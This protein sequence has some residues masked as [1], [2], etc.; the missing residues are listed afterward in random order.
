MKLELNKIYQGDVSRVLKTWPAAFI[1]TVVTSPPYWGLRDYGVKNQL[2]LERN[3]EEYVAK[4]VEIFREVRRCLRDDGTVWLNLGDSYAGSWGNYHPNSP[5]GKHGQRLKQT[6]R[7]NRPA[8]TAQD[9]LPP[10]ANCPNLKPKDLC[11]IPWRVAFALQADGWY[12]RSDIIWSKPNPMPE[13]VTDRPTKAHEYIFLLTKNQ[14]YFYDAEAIKEP[15]IEYERNRRLRE[16]SQGLDSTYNIASEGKTGQSPQG[17]TGS[18]KN[19]RRRQEL[20]VEGVRNKRTVWEVATQPYSEAHFATFPEKLIEPCILAGTSE[21]GCCV[22]CGAP[23]ERIFEPTGHEN[24]REPAHAPK[25]E[26]TKTDSTGWA[27]LNKF[28]GNWQPT[29]KCKAETKPCIA[30]DPFMG[31]GTTGLVALKFNRQFVGVEL[32]PKYIKMAERRIAHEKAQ[33]KMF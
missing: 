32:S 16:L 4:M 12:L 24:K 3:P 15:Q 31:S 28:S 25:S 29:C 9:R 19:S 27:P 2:G 14:A 8:Y 30:C 33:I 11:G 20:A 18:V 13:S 23:M 21:K 7:W 17:S 26:P 5:P 10:T 22:K 1:Q 6:A